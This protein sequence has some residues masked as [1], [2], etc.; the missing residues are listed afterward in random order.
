VLSFGQQLIDKRQT[1]RRWQKLCNG[2]FYSS[3]VPRL[4]GI[5]NML[6]IKWR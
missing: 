6:N 2:K 4:G 1:D 5:L 3:K